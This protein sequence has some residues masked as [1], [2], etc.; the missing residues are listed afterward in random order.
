MTDGSLDFSKTGYTT[1]T[2]GTALPVDL[3]DALLNQEGGQPCHHRR[4]KHW[5]V[6]QGCRF[7]Q[8]G[9]IYRPTRQRDPKKALAIAKEAVRNTGLEEW[10]VLSLSAGDYACLAGLLG[11]MVDEFYPQRVSTGLP[12]MR[13]ETL[14]KELVDVT[15][16]IRKTGFTLAPEAATDRM[17]KVISKNCSRLAS[18]TQA[19]SGPAI[20]AS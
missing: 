3:L 14:T 19:P 12:S 7:C 13:T 6:L 20:A 11:D 9:F 2:T 15:G 18:M 17:R 16:R 8:A 1:S 5:G 10:G 4:V